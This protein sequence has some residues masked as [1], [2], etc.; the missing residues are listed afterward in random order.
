MADQDAVLEA[1]ALVAG[2]DDVAVVREPVQQRCRQLCIDEDA[3]PFAEGQVG[4]DDDGGALIEPAD[5]VE[6]QLPTRLRKRQVAKLVDDD[7]V[8]ARQLLGETA[9]TTRLGLGLELV[10]QIHGIEVARLPSSLM[11]LLVMPIAMWLLPVPVPPTAT[12]LRC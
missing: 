11:Q 9:A 2:L 5:Q 7:Q 10:D 1:P 3:R 12:T 6:Q 8:D 4:R